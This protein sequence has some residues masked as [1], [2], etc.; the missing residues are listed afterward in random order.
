MNEFEKEYKDERLV[1]GNM[2]LS[3]SLREANEKIG[4]LQKKNEA[5]RKRNN[6]DAI[7]ISK[8]KMKK[9]IVSGGIAALIVAAIPNIVNAGKN[10][11]MGYKGS[12]YIADEVRESGIY[13]SR[14]SSRD[15]SNGYKFTYVDANGNFQNVSDTEGLIQDIL[16]ES[17]EYGFTLDQMA[18]A[19]DYSFGIKAYNVKGSTA[20][21][22]KVEK[23]KAFYEQ[24]QEEIQQAS[25]KGK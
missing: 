22:R 1:R 25:G 24:K 8:K 9:I 2:E 19:L 16:D 7:M 14:L 11:Y 3:A 10:A 13:P 17:P 21:G 23:M 5:L 15:T 4:R 12:S 6:D 20:D 18:I